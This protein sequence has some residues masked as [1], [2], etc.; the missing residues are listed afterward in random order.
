MA[1][2]QKNSLVGNINKRKRGALLA[3]RSSRSKK[4]STVSK[5][6]YSDMQKGW[7]K[8]KRRKKAR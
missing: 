5:Q 6:A 1:R 7:P 2:K 8:S 4:R 3:K